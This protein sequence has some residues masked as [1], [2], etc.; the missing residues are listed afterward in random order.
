MQSVGVLCVMLHFKPKTR[1]REKKRQTLT[2]FKTMFKQNKQ[3]NQRKKQQANKRTNK[4]GI[5]GLKFRPKY[6][7][8]TV[9]R[10]YIH[11]H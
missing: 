6:I 7:V 3:T 2:T 10:L 8:F 1:L 5:V 11:E 4:G 9:S